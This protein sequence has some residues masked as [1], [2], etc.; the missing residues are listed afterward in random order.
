MCHF[1]QRHA[2]GQTHLGPFAVEA[3]EVDHGRQ[4][5]ANV[6][7]DDERRGRLCAT[8]NAA[9]SLQVQGDLKPRETAAV[10]RGDKATKGVL[11]PQHT[12]AI[13][14]ASWATEDKLPSETIATG[15]TGRHEHRE[16]SR[17]DGTTEAPPHMFSADH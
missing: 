12:C 6:L 16:V 15:K 9:H 13:T 10:R 14:A 7:T 3:H 4:D 17:A 11:V 1:K 5:W 2:E 8:H